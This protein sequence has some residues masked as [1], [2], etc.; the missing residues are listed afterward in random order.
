MLTL[1]FIYLYL[2]PEATIPLSL[3]GNH[4]QIILAGDP[5]Q[6]GPVVLSPIAK[7][8]GLEK[9]LLCRLMDREPYKNDYGVRITTL[10]F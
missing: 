8:R 10:H 1:C 2:E 4:G 9:S 7:K 5:K 3:L 6:L